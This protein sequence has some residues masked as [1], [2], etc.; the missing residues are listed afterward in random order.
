MLE[1][2]KKKTDIETLLRNKLNQR[3]RTT[4]VLVHKVG[5][6]WWLVYGFLLNRMA[7]DHE[8]LAT[9]LSLITK[10]D[11]PKGRVDLIY[12]QR[13][14]TWFRKT[15]SIASKE[16]E[17]L[18]TSVSLLERIGEKKVYNYRELVLLFIA[19]LRAIG[20]NCRLVVNICP[21]PLKPTREQLI[22]MKKENE[23]EK[24]KD[25]VNKVEEKGKKKEKSK[26]S[27]AQGKKGTK[28]KKTNENKKSEK[29]EE[30]EESKK[31]LLDNSPEG[32]KN[33]AIEA[34]KKA[35]A[36]LKKGKTEKKS[37]ENEKTKSNSK[38]NDKI[39]ES[40]KEKIKTPLAKRL[41][42]RLQK[43]TVATIET[44]SDEDFIPQKK[45]NEINKNKV[46]Q[47]NRKLI[48]TDD[49]NQEVKKATEDIWV[50][51][52]VD[53]EKNWI[54]ISI[55]SAKINCVKEIFVSLFSLN[56]IFYFVLEIVFL[57]FFCRKKPWIL[58][59]ILLLII[60]KVK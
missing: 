1:R 55:P 47:K 17:R 48:S 35:A 26:N 4:Q 43:E 28:S 56:T 41:R 21:P 22:P 37:K 60:L 5:L 58:Y 29:E 24:D 39:K 8:T 13:V 9:C 12:L 31:I 11:Y 19:L 45:K 34:R 53:S 33:A 57:F 18:L 15:F 20:L 52:Y 30:E 6:L 44:D 3:I 7:N 51:V 54:P 2:K 38:I 46:I 42:N 49:E 50:E 16:E 14:T 10:N 32:R 25:K 59:Y 40:E 27:K 36:I 23:E